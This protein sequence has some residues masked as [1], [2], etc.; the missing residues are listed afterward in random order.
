MEN[1]KLLEDDLRD[2]FYDAGLPIPENGG[3]EV[4]DESRAYV[5]PSFGRSESSSTGAFAASILKV[6][7][8]LE[9]WAIPME[10]V[11]VSHSAG[12]FMFLVTIA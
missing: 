7:S 9:D 3:F 12:N 1:I 8:E 11:I 4:I 2:I 6:E 10:A 5:H